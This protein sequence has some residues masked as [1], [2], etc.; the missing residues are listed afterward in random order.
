MM[1][2]NT[3]PSSSFVL[4]LS[5]VVV[6]EMVPVSSSFSRKDILQSFL[7]IAAN[8]N[9][10]TAV[11]V[12]LNFLFRPIHIHLT[13]SPC[14]VESIV[15]WQPIHLLRFFWHKKHNLCQ[16]RISCCRQNETAVSANLMKIEENLREDQKN[17]TVNK[18]P[19]YMEAVNKTQFYGIFEEIFLQA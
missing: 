2:F 8:I 10:I 9:K 3:S 6:M 11:S 5:L 18:L 12:L 14:L 16:L 4:L 17:K 15:C 7:K 13:L 1:P 19:A